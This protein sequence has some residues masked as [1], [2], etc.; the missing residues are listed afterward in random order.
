M[1][2][3][4]R[5]YGEIKTEILNALSD[6]QTHTLDELNIRLNEKIGKVISK[7]HLCTSITQLIANGEEI[8][9]V[10]TGEYCMKNNSNSEINYH[11]Q[12]IELCK[13]W[14]KTLECELSYDMTGNQFE[15][16]RKLHE[17]NDRYI[18]DI[19]RVL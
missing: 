16:N 13:E 6:E 5:N 10:G 11:M 19:S 15:K 14:N 4:K 2:G 7:Q 18:K 3:K 12:I 8:V 1:D 9:R 17:L